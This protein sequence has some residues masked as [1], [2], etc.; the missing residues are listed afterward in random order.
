[1]IHRHVPFT[2]SSFWSLEVVFLTTMLL[3]NLGSQKLMGGLQKFTAQY[4]SDLFQV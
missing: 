2:W 3:F 1:M 4:F